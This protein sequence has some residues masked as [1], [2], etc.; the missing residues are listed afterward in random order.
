MREKPLESDFMRNPKPEELK[1]AQPWTNKCKTKQSLCLG[2]WVHLA[3]KHLPLCWQ[4]IPQV[5]IETEKL[6]LV[7]SLSKIPV[8]GH[9]WIDMAK[10][11]ADPDMRLA[12]SQVFA[13]ISYKESI[14][15]TPSYKRPRTHPMQDHVQRATEYKI[16]LLK[17]GLQSHNTDESLRFMLNDKVLIL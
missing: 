16:L 4:N 14:P 6:S 5:T 7:A 11:L 12:A 1:S 8:A 15:Q 9:L 10:I 2:Q 13:E 17:V 3:Q